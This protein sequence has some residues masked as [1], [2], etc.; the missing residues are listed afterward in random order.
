MKPLTPPVTNH[1]IK[2]GKNRKGGGR[3]G[4]PRPN[5]APPPEG[6]AAPGGGD[7]LGGALEDD[8]GQKPTQAKTWMAL[9]M[10][11]AMV[12]PLK[13]DS[14]KNGSPVANMW[15]SHTPK[16]ITIVATVP[17]TTMV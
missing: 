11:I 17:R 9:G 15:C 13:N 4:Q 14:A 2:P 6:L 16:P 10:T 5:V 8:R 3:T 7:G 12:A 1:A